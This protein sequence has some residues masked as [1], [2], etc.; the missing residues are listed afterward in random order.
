MNTRRQISIRALHVFALGG[1]LA[2]FLAPVRAAQGA[3]ASSRE[4]ERIQP[5]LLQLIDE[6]DK[7][8]EA[9]LRRMAA[10]RGI[11]LRESPAGALIPVLLE[12]RPGFSTRAINPARVE[13][14]GGRIDA[15]SAS[16]IRVLVLPH[17]A[18]RLADLSEVRSIRPPATVKEFSIGFGNV[19]SESV[20]LTGASTLQGI[21]ITGSGVKVAVVD[22]GFHRLA[23]AIAAHELPSNTVSV[24]FTGLGVE[25]GSQHGVAVAE[26]VVDMAPG[27]QLYCLRVGDEAD[28]ENAAAYLR[29][30]GIRVANLSLGWFGQSYYDDTGPFNTV[31]NASH[32]TDGV[33]WSVS[34]GNSAK[35]HWRG[36][37]SDPDGDE[38]LNFSPTANAITLGSFNSAAARTV[39]ITLNWNQYGNS[40]TDLDL[41]VVDKSGNTVASSTNPQ[42]GA[43]EPLEQLSFLYD[44]SKAPYRVVVVHAAGPTAGLDVTLFGTENVSFDFA[45]P[46]S[47]LADPADAHGATTI[48][49]IPETSY[50]I[51]NPAIES[52]SS[53]GPTNDGRT[54]PDFCA[55]DN[56][57]NYVYGLGTAFA[58]FDSGQWSLGPANK[59]F[60]GT[61]ASAPVVAGGAALLLQQT[62]SLTASQLVSAFVNQ[63][64]AISPPSLC[65]NGKFLVDP[66][67]GPAP[68]SIPQNMFSFGWPGAIPLYGDWN[69]DGVATAGVFDPTTATWYLRNEPG[70]G[71]PDLVFQFGPAG[72]IP[73]VGDWTGKGTTTV[74]VFVPSTAHWYLRYSNSSGA[75]D[76]AFQYG[77]P[78]GLPVVGDWKG[79]KVD[80]V[81]VYYPPSG[82]WLLRNSPGGGP[83]DLV[84]SFGYAGTKPLVGDWLSTRKDGIGLFD[85]SS[86]TLLLRSTPDTGPADFTS[87]SRGLK[88]MT[89]IAIPPSSPD[90]AGIAAS[91]MSIAKGAQVGLF[92][93]PTGQWTLQY[94]HAS[95]SPVA[96]F[97]YGGAGMV[98]VY[99]DWNGDGVATVGAFDP[100]TATWYLRNTPGPGPA[101]VVFQ[102]G[103]AGSIPVVG[104]WNGDG[105]T[106]VGV[107]VPSSAEWY[108]RNSNSA[109]TPDLA[110]HY[111][112][113][114]VMPI[115][116]NWTGGRVDGVGVYDASTGRWLLRN[117]PGGGSPDL[118]FSYGNPGTQ[119]VVGD[120]NASGHAGIGVYDAS[121]GV[122]WLRN[123]A[124][125]GMPD[126]TTSIGGGMTGRTAIVWQP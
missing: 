47:S 99:G 96:S 16:F 65:G 9:G 31:I 46:G 72:S 8:G 123:V 44:S 49:A 43:Q 38:R 29:T 5:R 103:T 52:F 63:A 121:S 111:G 94:G 64:L 113:S 101:E 83:A 35:S 79:D 22:V 118:V 77:F 6:Y 97:A 102:F 4:S 11:Q 108:L 74:G 1:L 88:G 30:N 55:P 12:L 62:P 80:T 34:A 59:D 23:E 60:R 67:T 105:A 50:A 100:S 81:G 66:V 76:L 69:G 117:S 33:F 120:W 36:T 126:L 70:P 85:P 41:Y 3:P 24:D 119:P 45:V 109:G 28:L 37:W 92:D 90:L 107:F 115:V 18:R 82:L 51:A 71:S 15:V 10:D 58:A 116:G 40:L 61:S 19:V 21:G 14:L 2:L 48:G 56:T 32:D 25:S 26:E 95:D 86:G 91:A 73:V 20:P 89:L 57:A 87:S 124:S 68:V 53:Q 110:F 54:K 13:A 112:W 122:F 106:T 98:P 125:A 17:D 7:N 27:V 42:T 114:G 84:F 104:D 78:G 75:P 93:S 39:G